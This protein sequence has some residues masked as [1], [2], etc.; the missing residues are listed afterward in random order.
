MTRRLSILCYSNKDV[1]NDAAKIVSYKHY[2]LAIFIGF[3]EGYRFGMIIK[4][5]IFQMY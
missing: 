1:I 4:V 5:I 3:Q 2:V